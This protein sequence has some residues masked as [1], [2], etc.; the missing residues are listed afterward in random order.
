MIEFD[1]INDD[2]FKLVLR[3]DFT[4]LQGCFEAKAYK[5]VL[6]LA[7]SIVESVLL[8][9]YYN[10]VDLSAREGILKI[11]LFGLIDLAY[12]DKILSL[13]SKDL[14]SVV[15]TYRNLIHPGKEIRLNE[16]VDEESAS[17]AISLVKMIV[18]EVKEYKLKQYG[19]TARDILGKLSSD[20]YA[21]AIYDQLVEKISVNE[22]I[23]LMN[24]LTSIEIDDSE[25]GPGLVVINIKK[26]I[27]V[28]KPSIPTEE[29]K[30]K[31]MELVQLVHRGNSY[32]IIR[33]YNLYHSD[34]GLVEVNDRELVL[35]YVLSYL[36]ENLTPEEFSF[37]YRER[38]FVDIGNYIEDKGA[39][40]KA[41]ERFVT[42]FIFRFPFDDDISN[43]GVDVFDHIINSLNGIAATYIK[44]NIAK[45]S[46]VAS[47]KYL[48]AKKKNEL[49]F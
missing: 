43:D 2:R 33:M 6:V 35:V 36:Y 10:T 16:T 13:R 28:L 31:V 25:F 21:P 39:V 9:H 30:K 14:S 38:T 41:L 32:Q 20:S 5:A 49:P 1:F 15:R 23:K 47:K 46:G 45:F 48:E 34:L 18:K 11:D 19:Y 42:G 4:E 8:D 22:R 7:G 12:K 3:R 26:R 40:M 44:D 29:R 24:E 37:F 17:V 27:E